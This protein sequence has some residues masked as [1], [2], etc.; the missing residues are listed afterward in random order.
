MVP[1][2]ETL[3][4][5]G[6]DHPTE[7][8]VITA[9]AF[10][11]FAEQNVDFVVLEVGLGGRFDATNVVDPVLEVLTTISLD[12]INVLGDN[13]AKIAYEKAGIIKK[14]KPLIL[15]PQ[16]KEAHDVIMEVAKE[17]N[18]KIYNVSDVKDEIVSESVDGTVY[19]VSGTVKYDNLHIGILGY[20][21]VMNTKTA[22]LA[23]KALKELG[24]EISDEAVYNGLLEARWPARFEV[25]TKDPIIVLDGGHNVQGIE[26]LVDSVNKYFKGKKIKI[27]CGMLSDKDYNK[28]I[29]DLL[30]I[31]DNFV[32]VTPNNDRALTSEELATI[33][34]Q[35]GYEAVSA[36]CITEAVDIALQSRE[37]DEMLVFCGSLYMIGEVRGY[38]KEKLSL[39]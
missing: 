6:L 7:F 18:A 26:A 10:K 25:L 17:M 2:V 5:E 22:L 36:S 8:E 32:T 30:S 39:S 27:T 20:Y 1:H 34:R 13:I 12:H 33:I 16:V 9:V 3:V 28:M 15:Y 14:D 21:Q 38:I 29:D 31:G 35:K 19:N 4:K 11:Y 37:E 24:Y 23:V